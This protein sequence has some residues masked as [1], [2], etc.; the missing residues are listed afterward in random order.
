MYGILGPKEFLSLS[1]NGRI[2]SNG[3]KGM[4]T[5]YAHDLNRTQSKTLLDSRLV[6][7]I[8]PRLCPFYV[9]PRNRCAYLGAIECL[10]SHEMM[11]VQTALVGGQCVKKLRI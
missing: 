9:H 1:L 8:T 6:L 4:C 11:Q 3:V 10:R 2:R 7:K 5:Y